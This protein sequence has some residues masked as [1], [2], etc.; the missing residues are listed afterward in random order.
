MFGKTAILSLLV[1][2]ALRLS[3]GGSVAAAQGGKERVFT[4]DSGWVWHVKPIPAF[5]VMA[6]Q[7]VVM[8]LDEVKDGRLLLTLS[9]PVQSNRD[10]V[11]F[12]PVGFNA[13]GRR[14]EFT[15]DSG[16]ATSG[17]TLEGFFLN[18][19]ELPLDQMEHLGIEKLTKD[20]LRDILAPA[21]FQK[22][23]EAGVEAL[24]FPRMGER[25]D[26]QLTALDGKKLRSRD[27]RGEVLLLDFWARWC[28]PC[29]AKMPKLREK[30]Q[31]FHK[32]GFEII[33]INHDWELAAAKRTIAEQQLLW[34]NVLAPVD[35]GQREL[36]QTATGIT[37]LPHLLLIDRDGILRADTSPR[38]LDE[39]I[40]KLMAKP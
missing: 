30:Y 32:S 29:M 36:W 8:R 16:V 11:R 10:V 25:Y 22:L 7:G 31:Q 35:S 38:D 28:G 19:N 4:N 39:E 12:R 2:A 37:G 20:N 40:D 17:V 21:A 15:P 6:V 9:Y 24:P 18:L 5:S 26:F 13:A 27:F 3:S 1:M 14:F 34:P 23:R 33:G